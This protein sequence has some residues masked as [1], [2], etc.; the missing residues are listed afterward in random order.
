MSQ[1]VDDRLY[2]RQL[3]SGRDFAIA[4][5]VASQMVNFVYLIGDKQT[6]ECVVVDPAYAVR[7]ILQI[8]EQ[9]EMTLT[10]V[11]ATHYHPDHVGGSMMGM[12]IQGIAD[13]LQHTQVPI[14]IN[15][16]ETKWVTR[17]TGVSEDSIIQHSGGDKLKVGE[18]EITFVHT[19]GHTPGSQCFLVN[20]RL[21][22]GDTL[23]LDGCG[24]TDLPG[25]NPTELYES[26]QILASLPLET[27]V[28][29][30]HQYSALSSANLGDVVST[31][32]VFRP[33]SKQQW[34][35]W[36]GH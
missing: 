23:F 18:I 33:N 11:L 25:G 13:V 14:H 28:C 35:E 17:T 12:K 26:L 6:R 10:G 19:P 1:Q 5:Q 27:I 36:F 8:V 22:A 20:Q 30:G 24:R 31:N 34:L 29:P 15:Q 2:F 21:V 9:D 16:N 32:H 3:L 7:D 4:D